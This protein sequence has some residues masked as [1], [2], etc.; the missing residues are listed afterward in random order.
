MGTKR[1]CVCVSYNTG[2]KIKGMC[3]FIYVYLVYLWT[4][5]CQFCIIIL[6][7]LC[8]ENKILVLFRSFWEISPVCARGR[9]VYLCVFV[10]MFVA[11]FVAIIIKTKHSVLGGMRKHGII[12]ILS[13]N[14]GCLSINSKAR[15]L[16]V[17]YTLKGDEAAEQPQ[18]KHKNI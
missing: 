16:N 5:V 1:K 9:V 3:P 11:V 2:F 17:A 10:A 14:I 15:D 4:C 13:R 8:G 6:S 12:H 7:F 18:P